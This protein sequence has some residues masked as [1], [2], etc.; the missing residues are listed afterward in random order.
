MR[1]QRVL[2]LKLPNSC[3]WPRTLGLRFVHKQVLVW[4]N[5]FSQGEGPATEP[6]VSSCVSGDGDLSLINNLMG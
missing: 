4:Y 6:T 2:V 3:C 5:P 1:V